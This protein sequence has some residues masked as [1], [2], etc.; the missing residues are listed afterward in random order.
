LNDDIDF[1]DLG[2]PVAVGVEVVEQDDDQHQVDMD[3]EADLTNRAIV[4]RDTVEGYSVANA[5]ERQA[6]IDLLS[7]IKRQLKES[8]DLRK[9]LTQPINLSLKTINARFKEAQEPLKAADQELRRKVLEYD[10]DEAAKQ[11]AAEE[12]A[13]KAARAAADKAAET[14]KPVAVPI[15]PPTPAAPAKTTRTAGGGTATRR[16]TWTFEVE[17]ESKIPAEY[18]VPD[19]KKIGAV[20]KAGVRE[21]AGVKIFKEEGLTIR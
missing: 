21:I 3:R 10:K 14:G 12:E 8:E 17:D 6:A 18:M 19:T 16:E 5:G 9:E 7:E 2:K 1:S 13:M 11:K 15:A 20:V 4:Y